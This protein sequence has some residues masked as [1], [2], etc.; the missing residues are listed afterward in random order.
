MKPGNTL[1]DK[2]AIFWTDLKSRLVVQIEFPKGP[3]ARLCDRIWKLLEGPV[4][5]WEPDNRGAGSY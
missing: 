4:L 1:G 3:I 2:E 5:C